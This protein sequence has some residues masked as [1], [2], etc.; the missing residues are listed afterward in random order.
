MQ[1]H[2]TAT[3]KSV[4]F[5][6]KNKIKFSRGCLSFVL[7]SNTK[8]VCPYKVSL[9]GKLFGLTTSP[10]PAP[11]PVS[12]YWRLPEVPEMLSLSPTQAAQP[13]EV[14]Q[15]Q[16]ATLRLSTPLPSSPVLRREQHDVGVSRSQRTVGVSRDCSH[17]GNTSSSHPKKL[18][19][20]EGNISII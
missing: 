12:R 3:N 1:I 15:G 11:V 19:E 9:S 7:S 2:L 14:R 13:P 17:R 6:I 4:D 18:K 8:E 16:S 10:A 5:I 20:R